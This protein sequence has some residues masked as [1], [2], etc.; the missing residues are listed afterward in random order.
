MIQ[1]EKDNNA[2]RDQNRDLQERVARLENGA[3]SVTTTAA[4]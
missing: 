4:K 2:L 1:Q 3:A